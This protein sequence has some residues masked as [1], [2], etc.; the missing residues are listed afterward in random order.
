MNPIVYEQLEEV[1][2]RDFE[3]LD[4]PRRQWPV[5]HQTAQ[6]QQIYDCVIVGGGQ[7]GLAV[8]WGLLR[9]KVKTSSSLMLRPKVPKALAHFWGAWSPCARPNI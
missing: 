4:Y 9:D 5:A 1:L 2:Q 8:A 6:G 7:G 3:L